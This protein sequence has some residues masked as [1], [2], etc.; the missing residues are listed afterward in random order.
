MRRV[1][2]EEL[3]A[4]SRRWRDDFNALCSPE[5]AEKLNSD[6]A[7]DDA[8]LSLVV[9]KK[10][11]NRFQRNLRMSWSHQGMLVGFERG[12]VAGRYLLKGAEERR[13]EPEELAW[14]RT[15]TNRQLCRRLD[16][17]KIALPKQYAEALR[18]RG[19]TP[20]WEMAYMLKPKLHPF[21]E[22]LRQLRMRAET[23]KASLNIYRQHVVPRRKL[24][25]SSKAGPSGAT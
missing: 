5:K 7:D 6:I 20:S 3:D 18:H 1:R 11:L 2:P 8:V 12:W 15:L 23:L 10:L 4:K 16:E 21:E 19:Q 22:H 25:K 13:N 24:E 17:R 14:N 9:N